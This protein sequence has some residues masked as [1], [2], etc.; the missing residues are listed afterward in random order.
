LLQNLWST[1]QFFCKY[2]EKQSMLPEFEHSFQH[3]K[4]ARG[5]KVGLE[6]NRHGQK[7]VCTSRS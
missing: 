3:T 2:G 6:K 1:S 5:L 4:A 7:K